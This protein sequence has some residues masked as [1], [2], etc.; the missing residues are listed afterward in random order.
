[1]ELTY[2]LTEAEAL[3]GCDDGL[4]QLRESKSLDDLIKCYFDR[5][6]YCLANNF[7]SNEFLKQYEKD[8]EPYVFV[9]ANLYCG[10]P[11]CSVFL[12]N[13][14]CKI[15]CHDYAVSRIYVKHQSK[16]N[17]EASGNAIVMV[18]ALDDSDVIV[19]LKDEAKVIVNLYSK[20]TCTGATKIIQKNRETYDL[21]TR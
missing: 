12:G 3:N 21:Q 5:I 10:N 18:D 13:S 2:L 15:M 20:A 8:L 7:P 19:D 1:M 16:I 9:D 17:I 11:R 4:Q 14:V 6:D